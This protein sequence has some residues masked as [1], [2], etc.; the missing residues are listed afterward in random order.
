MEHFNRDASGMI[1]TGKAVETAEPTN[2]PTIADMTAEQKLDEIL[3]TMRATQDLV[4]GFIAQFT[5]SGGMGSI[6]SVMKMFGK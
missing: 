5:K 3:A 2:R 4:E 6:L 1:T